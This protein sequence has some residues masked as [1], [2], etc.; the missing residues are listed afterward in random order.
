ML[1]LS[2]ALTNV[3]DEGCVKVANSLVKRLKKADEGTRVIAFE[4]QSDLADKYVTVNKLLLNRRLISEVRKNK[5]S[6]MY[7]PFPAKTRSVALRIFILSLFAGKNF[8]VMLSMTSGIDFLSKMLLKISR[9][10]LT[11]FSRRSFEL[12]SSVVGEK[13]VEYLKAGVDSEKFMPVS[14]DRANELKE[15]FGF[16]ADK[17]L[18]LHVGHLNRGRNV[19]QLE[20]LSE[21]YQTLLITS[22]QTKGEQDAELKNELLSC[23]IK[24][25]DTY[26]PDI[27]QVYQMADVYLFPVV[28]QGRCIDVPLSCMEAAACNRPIVTTD[29]GEMREFIG[30]DGF[31]F[32]ESFETDKLQEKIKEALSAQDVDTRSAVLDYDWKNA[33]SKLAD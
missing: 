29:F 22:T 19:Q 3:V 2:N 13:R 16:D 8:R 24:I 23:G 20:K 18:V 28:E 1:I 31:Y 30:K 21:D 15:K 11:V 4:R 10:R 33:V 25:I 14:Q 17:K 9:A 7:I 32:I 6:V 12:Y 26:I 27:E 5:G